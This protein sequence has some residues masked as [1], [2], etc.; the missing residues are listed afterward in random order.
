MIGIYIR[1]IITRNATLR[2]LY[3][4]ILV[5]NKGN[6]KLIKLL[7]ISG[8]YI[9]LDYFYEFQFIAAIYICLFIAVYF[10]KNE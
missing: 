6:I 7:S 3:K 10:K 8:I 4:Y 5:R 9:A 1:R 2:K